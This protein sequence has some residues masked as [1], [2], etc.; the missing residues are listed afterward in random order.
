MIRVSA[1]DFETFKRRRDPEVF[2]QKQIDNWVT[3]LSELI[4]KSDNEELND[5]EKATLDEFNAEF[6]SFMKVEVVKRSEDLLSKGLEYEVFF[7]REKQVEW[8]DVDI[9]KSIDGEEMIDR[10]RVAR[11]L[12]TPLNRKL[13][14]VG[15]DLVKSE[16]KKKVDTIEKGGEGSRG[17]RVIGRTRT[18]KPIY[19]TFD[20]PAHANFTRNDHFDAGN[21]HTTSNEHVTKHRAA[22]NA[23]PAKKGSEKH[24]EMIREEKRAREA[25]RFH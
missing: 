11:F 23:M 4:I 24:P 13:N 16:D 17:G 12:D 25:K 19:D 18:G 20:H 2:T 8:V 15:E 9:T 10:T 14:R 21:T 7:V 1:Q 3:G 6:N 5:I 22:A